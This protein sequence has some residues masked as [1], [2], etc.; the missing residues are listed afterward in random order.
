M[1]I[2]I[3]AAI[4]CLAMIYGHAVYRDIGNMWLALYLPFTAAAF[5][6]SFVAR[7]LPT[8]ILRVLVQY[9]LPF[10]LNGATMIHFVAGYENNGPLD[11]TLIGMTFFVLGGVAIAGIA[12]WIPALLLVFDLFRDTFKAKSHSAPPKGTHQETS[13][14]PGR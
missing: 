1:R 11:V 6:A 9:L 2:L 7:R 3:P 13:P 5:L 10:A 4:V 8:T 14:P 12:P